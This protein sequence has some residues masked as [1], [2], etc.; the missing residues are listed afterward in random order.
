MCA[1]NEDHMR[2]GFSDVRLDRQSFCH[3]GPFFALD[4]PNNPKNQNFEKMKKKNEKISSFYT[5]VP[6][7][8]IRCYK[9]PKILCA[10]ETDGQMGKV[11][12][13]G[14]CTVFA[15]LKLLTC[16]SQTSLNQI[17]QD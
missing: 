2:Y 13:R 6:K 5:C 1:I 10:T 15:V 4:P 7:I 11:I 16:R 3:V 12:Y 14:G 9:I 8:M 17:Q